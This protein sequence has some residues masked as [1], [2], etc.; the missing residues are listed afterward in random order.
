MVYKIYGYI[1]LNVFSFNVKA[2]ILVIK[3]RSAVFSKK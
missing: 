3:T 1:T 2:A